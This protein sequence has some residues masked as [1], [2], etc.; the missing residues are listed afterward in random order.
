ML[1]RAS[2]VALCLAGLAQAALVRI[3]LS[4]RS[5]VLDGKSFG[6]AGPYER[7][8]GKAYF[9]VDPKNP[10]NR[11]IADIDN[12]PRNDQGLV[13]FSSDL[14]ILKPRDP[15]HGNGSVLFEVSNR[16]TKYMLGMYDRAAGSLDPRTPEQLG[17]NF[18]LDRGFTLV[19]L[20]WQ[21][22]V[23]RRDGL[24]RLYAP[25][26]HDG[27]RPITGLVRS[28]FVLDRRETSY[29][30]S[31]RD[32]IPYPVLHPDDSKLTL[33]VRDTREG[34]RRTVPRGDW[35]IENRT[36]IVMPAGFEPGK[37]YELVYTAQ[38]PTLV[39]LGPAAVRDLI[40]FFKYGGNDVTVLGDSR[41]YIKRAYGFG[42]SQSGRFLRTFLYYGFNR[43][44]RDRRVFDGV[45][46]HVAGGAHGSFN[47][48][49]AQPSR[50]A[51]PFYNTFY[52]TDIF[53]FTDLDETDPE[54]GLTEGILTR[55]R[56]DNVVPK[57]F[58]SNTAYEYWG[59][60]ASLIHISID[61]QKDAPIPDTTRIYFFAGGQ[62]GPASFPPPRNHT[63]NLSNPNDFRWS[64]RALLVAMDRWVREGVEP[65][66]SQYPRIAQDTL[67]PL[68]A[69]QF[70]KI[71]GVSLPTVIQKAY[72]VD[73]GPQFRTEGI[74][75]IEPPKV[76][77]AFPI[78]LPQVDQDGNDTS[79]V[80]MPEIQVPLATYTG[81]NLRSP[82]IGAP[83]EMFSMQ[84][85]FIPF[86]RTKADREL[87]R[88]PRA[89]IEERYSG[90][91]QYLEKVDAAARSLAANGYLLSDDVPD[92][93][94]HSATEWDYL[95]TLP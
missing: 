30:V 12:A 75:T 57:I 82:E 61:G 83:T 9:A 20:G 27:S 16:G 41:N 67:V 23:P 89:S 95:N 37:L 2:I 25:V 40:S 46:S 29:S 54:T 43:D 68:G 81:W 31:D 60:S 85:S 33:T 56:K 1:K 28:E 39:G 42:I 66:A 74:V 88:D 77:N 4:E 93:V 52:P 6:P 22:D 15:A 36:R 44:E 59:R 64:M 3:E 48:R 21:F 55:A 18:L 49:F 50:D 58:Y 69:V 34:A 80:R 72:R 53:P 51:H 45:L 65:P 63:Q 47:H 13:E 91:A 94:E 14:Y 10:A 35:H 38:D 86:A 92:I 79:G 73:Y 76:G 5:D 87:H 84:G 19:W 70:P 26:A 32:H 24:M 11:I 90:R 78:L 71:P 62:H 7:L 17:D 8:V